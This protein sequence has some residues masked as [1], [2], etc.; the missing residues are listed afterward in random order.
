MGNFI[1]TGERVKDLDLES[2]DPGQ[3]EY[4]LIDSDKGTQKVKL[5]NLAA[6]KKLQNVDKADFHNKAKQ[7]DIGFT[8]EDI[9]V[10]GT[11]IGAIEDGQTIPAGTS[12]NAFV[13]MAARKQIPPTYTS[14]TLSLS[15]DPSNTQEVGS[16]IEV[17]LSADFENHDGGAANQTQYFLNDS[18]IEDQPGLA[19]DKTHNLTVE[20]GDNDYKVQVDYNQGPVKDDNLGNPYPDGQIPAG[21]KTASKSITGANYHFYGPNGNTPPADGT[22][23]RA[24]GKTFANSFTLNTGVTDKVFVIAVPTSKA[25]D[26]VID[27]DALNANITASFVL[28]TTITTVP[29][30]SGADVN[31][32]V[33]VMENAV[34]FPSN[35]RLLTTLKNA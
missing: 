35:H 30:A 13:K 20:L 23:V 16:A 19:P 14:P 10:L 34:A 3:D 18:V 11:N 28:S 9:P 4:A 24:L 6:A 25:L 12:V 8:T 15:I 31:Y 22:E 26:K 21:S 5:E 17:Q 29:D 32:N 33:Y 1:D 7:A 2:F 27:Q